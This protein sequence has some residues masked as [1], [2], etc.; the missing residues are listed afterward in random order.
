MENS[1]VVEIAPTEG[2][3]LCFDERMQLSLVGAR[4]FNLYPSRYGAT[5]INY[6]MEETV[7]LCGGLSGFKSENYMEK[8]FRDN[9]VWAVI[10]NERTQKG[11]G[12]T[13]VFFIGDGDREYAVDHNWKREWVYDVFTDTVFYYFTDQEGCIQAAAPVGRV[14]R[15][16]EMEISRF[17]PVK[18]ELFEEKALSA[19]P[20]T[21]TISGEAAFRLLYGSYML[22][23]IDYLKPNLQNYEYARIDVEIEGKNRSLLPIHLG[24]W[25]GDNDYVNEA[26]TIYLFMMKGGRDIY[27]SLLVSDDDHTEP[28][29]RI[30]SV[31]E[32]RRLYESVNGEIT[33]ALCPLLAQD[34]ATHTASLA[35]GRVDFSNIDGKASLEVF[36]HTPKVAPEQEDQ[37]L[38]EAETQA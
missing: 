31:D 33:L 35:D 29:F 3:K 27:A 36:L 20:R 32:L 19:S 13:P 7:I 26:P 38:E 10:R 21:I 2:L 25:G 5:S 37:A 28:L 17:R 15:S 14:P 1:Q 23:D 16:I 24:G 30:E 18:F 12:R 8:T 22:F 11:Q 6:S 34:G 4:L 9:C